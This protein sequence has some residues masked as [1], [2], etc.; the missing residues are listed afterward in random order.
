MDRIRLG[1]RIMKD[2]DEKSDSSAFYDYDSDGIDSYGKAEAAQFTWI[3]ASEIKNF[4][5]DSRVF[6]A[7]IP[8]AELKD[9][10][11][12]NVEYSFTKNGKTMYSDELN[13][14]LDRTGISELALSYD[15]YASDYNGTE[16]QI[17]M[18]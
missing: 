17:Y 13:V 4:S 8:R 6:L 16:Y 18:D 15:E 9:K 2:S 3:D 10:D 14:V 1:Y 5:D 7:K 11:G 12:F